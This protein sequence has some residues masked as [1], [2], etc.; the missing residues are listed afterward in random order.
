MGK[1]DNNVISRP[2]CMNTDVQHT[3]T[4]IT[5]SSSSCSHMHENYKLNIL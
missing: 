3:Y 4:L 5:A 1:T 2:R